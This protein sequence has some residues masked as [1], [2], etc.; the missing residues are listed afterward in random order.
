M[1]NEK[2]YVIVLADG[3]MAYVKAESL[4]DAMKAVKGN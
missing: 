2:T 1:L 3:T 4:A